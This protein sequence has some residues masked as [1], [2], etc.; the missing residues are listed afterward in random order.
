M[1]LSLKTPRVRVYL[2]T[3]VAGEYLEIDVQTDNRDAVQWDFA[4]SRQRW[5]DGREAPLLW[6]T[7]LSWH[8]I[9]RTGGPAPADFEEFNKRC[10][11]VEALNRDGSLLTPDTPADDAADPTMPEP[12][13]A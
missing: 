6:M 4:R 1:T 13:R 9:R 7:Y 3:D 12:E 11:D 8:A 5:P 2:E 10:V